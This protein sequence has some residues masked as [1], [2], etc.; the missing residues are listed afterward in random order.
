MIGLE[1]G[2]GPEKTTVLTMGL[3]ATGVVR[4]KHSLPES[5]P[6]LSEKERAKLV[7]WGAER[8]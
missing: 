1:N 5:R 8:C 7:F 6:Q 2:V 3:Y 4:S